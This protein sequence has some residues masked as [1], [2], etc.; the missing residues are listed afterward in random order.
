MYEPDRNSGLHNSPLRRVH[1]TLV[2]DAIAF[3]HALF[4]TCSRW[5]TDF[6]ILTRQRAYV[7]A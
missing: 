6:L 5:I 7:R 1:K 3:L 4:V 2:H